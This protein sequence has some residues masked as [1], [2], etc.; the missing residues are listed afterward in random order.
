VC[1]RDSGPNSGGGARRQSAARS[2]R[3]RRTLSDR[4]RPGQV[5][6][7]AV[8]PKP[9]ICP[10]ADDH[11]QYRRPKAEE[12]AH[13]SIERSAD[14]Y[15]RRDV[16]GT[17]IERY[18]EQDRDGGGGSRQRLRTAAGTLVDSI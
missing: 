5:R 18:S 3:L 7:Q 1:A 2:R 16:I 17:S 11:D 8:A 10:K 12:Q 4:Q 14:R 15:R 9:P 6:P 13:R